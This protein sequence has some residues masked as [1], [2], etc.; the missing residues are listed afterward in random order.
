MNRSVLLAGLGTS[1]LLAACNSDSSSSPSTSSNPE[2]SPPVVVSPPPS[3]NPAPANPPGSGASGGPGVSDTDIPG[4][5]ALDGLS[6]TLPVDGDHALR[7]IAPNILELTR[8][9]IKPPD[10]ATVDVWNFVDASGNATLPAATQFA[11]TVNGQPATVQAV[12]F[13]RRALYAPL[14]HRDLRVAS[15]LYL[16]IGTA[17]GADQPVEVNN[18]G[19][20]LW[21]AAMAFTVTARPL[22]FGP[23]VHV[24]E[25]GYLP[26]RP[27]KAFVG[28][29]LGSLGELDVAEG[30]GF[31]VVDAATGAVVFSGSLARRADAGW[32]YA[33]APYQQVCEADFTG[34]NTPGRYRVLVPGLGASVPFRIDEGIAMDFARAYALGLYHQRCGSA[35]AMPYTRFTHDA[36]HVNPA[37]IPSGAGFDFT[38]SIVAQ[39]ANILNSNNP[40][41]IAARLTSEAA[42][43][44]PFVN[45]GSIDVSGGH[46]DA[47]DYSKYTTNSAALI[48]TL[49][50]SA[51]SLAGA[52]SLDNLGVPES[53]DGISD[54][55][56]E[57]KIEADFLAKMQ[58]A[59]GGFYF[60]V[61]PRQRR[62][63]QNVLPDQGDAQVVWPKNT[64]ASAGATAALAEIASSPRFKAAYP[65]AAATYLAK[66]KTGWKFLTDAIAKYGKAGAYQ[67]ITHYGDDF[68]HDDEL[69][70]AAAAMFAAT[71]DA[72]IHAT[73]KSW[74]DPASPDTWRWGWWHCYMGY[75]NAVRT[76]AFAARSGRLAASQLDAAYLAKCEAEVRAAADDAVRWSQQSAYGTSFPD[77]TKRVRGAGW[78]FSGAQAFDVAVG[79]QLDARADYLA[80]LIANLNYEGG[81]NPVNVCYV[82]GLGRRRQHDIVHQYAQN[83]RRDL[84]PSGF[85]LGNVQ[86]GPVYNGTYGTELAALSFPGDNAGT[87]PYPYYDRW[88]DTHNVTTEF[89]VID[90]ARG[91]GAYAFLAAQT[92]LKSQPWTSVAGVIGGLPATLATGQAVTATLSAPG[93]DLSSATTVWEAAGHAAAY[94]PSFTFT[95]GDGQQWV[96]AEAALPD[97]RRIFAVKNFFT[98]NGRANVSVAATDDTATF[99]D[100]TD[101]ATFTF[102]RTGDTTA[103]LTVQYKLGGSAVKWNDYRR[104][105]GD[106]PVEITI[107]AGAASASFSILA[108]ANTTNANPATVTVTVTAGST[109]NAGNPSTATA[110]LKN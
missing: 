45:K 57:A 73:L 85:P 96:E 30:T 46:H 87:A 80:T 68:T 99:G 104:P 48:H 5:T 103:A 86:A 106:M 31:Q 9:S 21:P 28:Y 108:V 1:L 97:G 13:R 67:K 12:G 76:Y 39:E 22:R 38:W 83:D 101:T 24:N 81:A 94:G 84:P 107:P 78:Y 110:T 63:E 72:S 25:E 71:G 89:V 64:A 88:T 27:K 102:T 20:S 69:A 55:L 40:T 10:P 19:G 59:D 98:D 37:A 15:S 6:L 36:C 56:Q 54:L 34:F 91:L 4:L 109:Y 70:W 7:V 49:V 17:V 50:F 74:F 75:G 95:P 93:I 3:T 66:A 82:T 65:A 26:N 14:A 32:S 77:A 44:Y 58:D 29:Y 33:P 61:Y 43:L 100:P 8:V 35:N 51:D 60:L 53:G 16:R 47:G 2:S 92:S 105:E 90:Q 23:A 42:M 79:W 41:Q 18:P 52:G 11:V 62:Y